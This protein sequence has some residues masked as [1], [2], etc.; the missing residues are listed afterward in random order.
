MV[1]LELEGVEIDHCFSCEGI[2]LDHGE[3][4]LL[5]KDAQKAVDLLVSVNALETHQKSKKKCPICQRKM[6][7]KRVAN[8]SK[9]WIDACPKNHG[10]WFDR[11]E[12]EQV[13]AQA[14]TPDALKIAALI[15]EIFRHSLTQTK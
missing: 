10:L 9:L 15:H 12:L 4:S 14:K 3:I 2:W 13:L 8:T 6:I 7:S 1:I 5:L 11:G